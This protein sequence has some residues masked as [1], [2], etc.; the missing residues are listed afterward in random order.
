M[1][2]VV[3]PLVSSPVRLSFEIECSIPKR[4]SGLNIQ[5]IGTFQN[6]CRYP[7]L[8]TNSESSDIHI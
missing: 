2:S 8:Y 4:D 7:Q 1:E 5:S 3:L 6:R